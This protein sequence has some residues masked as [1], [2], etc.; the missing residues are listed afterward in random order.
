MRIRPAGAT[1]VLATSLVATVLLGAG[2]AEA[3]GGTGCVPPPVAH[4]GDSARAPENTMPAFRMALDLGVTRLEIDVR[5]TSSGTPVLMHDATVDR[6]TNGT[7][8]VASMALADLRALDAGS[9]FSSSYVGVKVPTLYEV[10]YLGR[11]R[12]ATFLIELKTRPTPEQM[13]LFLYRIRRLGMLAR[14]RVT[15]F[16]EQTLLDVRTAQPGLRTAIIDRRMVREPDSVLPY[17]NTYV[18]HKSSVT[19]ER[20]TLWRAAGIDVRPWTVDSV[21]A[22]RQMA[23]DQVGA[24]I[25]DRPKRYLSWARSVCS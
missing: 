13:N 20:A 24:T 23:T 25:T 10:L 22:W 14:V 8:E 2:P 21:R 7:G 1:L 4:R 6:T 16:D 12:G 19:A 17:G 3:A 15:S 18:V 5:F 9:W 11:T